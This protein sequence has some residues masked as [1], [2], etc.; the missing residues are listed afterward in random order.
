MALNLLVRFRIITDRG[1]NIFALNH[2]N[3]Y[4]DDSAEALEV[5]KFLGA[6]DPTGDVMTTGPDLGAEGIDHAI[7]T[8]TPIAYSFCDGGNLQTFTH[9]SLFPYVDKISNVNHFSCASLVCDLQISD[10]YT[11]QGASDFVT[12]DGA[13]EVTATSSNGDIKFSLDPGFDFYTEGQTVGIFTGLYAG[14]YTVT[15]KDELGCVDQITL[16]VPVPDFYNPIYRLEYDATKGAEGAPTSPTRIDILE[17]G[18][19]GDVTE[20]KGDADPFILRYNGAGE[21]NKFTPIIPSEARLTIMSETNFQFRHLFTQDERKYQIRYYKNLGTATPGFTPYELTPLENWQ[22]ILNGDFD[23]DIG[24]TQP[25]VEFTGSSLSST[26]SEITSTYIFEPGHLY[27]FA[28]EFQSLTSTPFGV[29]FTIRIE[30]VSGL[31]LL[32]KWVHVTDITSGTYSF[33]APEGAARITV[34]VFVPFSTS[35]NDTYRINSFTNQ[36]ATIPAGDAGPELKWLGYVI[37]SN[38]SEA[39][40]APPYPVQ[41]VATDGLADLKTYDYLDK[42]GNKYRD[43]QNTLTAITEILAKTDLSINI[44][45]AI[46]RYEE[47]MDQTDNDDPVNQCKFDPATFYHNNSIKSCAEVLE[48]LLK[49]FGARILQRNGKWC[50]YSIEEFVTAAD[51]REFDSNGL[52]IGN[53]TFNDAVNIDSP[54][55]QQRAA[56]INREQVLSM[57]PAYGKFFFEHTLLKNGSLIASYSF[58]LE[59]IIADPSGLV[60]F[61]NWNVNIANS[62]GATYGLKET[63]DIEGDFTFYLKYVLY[64]ANNVP[65]GVFLTAKPFILEYEN[66]DVFEF[67]FNYASLYAPVVDFGHTIWNK[68]K[69]MLKV[70]SYYYNENGGWTT[71]ADQKYN[72]VIIETANQVSEKRITGLL[73]N[74]S[75]LTEETVQIEFVLQNGYTYDYVNISAL[76]DTPTTT[77]AIGARKRVAQATTGMSYYKL[78]Y[79]TDAE[80]SPDIIRPDDYATTTN[81]RIWVREYGIVSSEGQ[82][83]EYNYIDNV[84]LLLHPKGAEA[85]ANITTTRNNNAGIKINFEEQYLL[86]D[87]DLENINNSERT[88]KNYFKKLDGTPTQVWERTYRAGTGKLLDLLSNDVVS[89][90]KRGSNKLTGSFI[91]DRE[92]LPTSV[93]IDVNG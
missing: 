34:I 11:I 71:D 46:N 83:V 66:V 18:Y 2:I 22:G 28:Y 52:L 14:E 20:I 5:Q 44:Q 93:M 23:W 51:Y 64:T 4:W 82:E 61:K 42:D 88:Y 80:S 79:G 76:K 10:T 19:T 59:D 17:R 54:I 8:N 89:Q 16:N 56:F 78:Q 21:I 13:L 70:G 67:S 73:R 39:Y 91:V 57:I 41:I 40:L 24:S 38:Y 85:P 72:D 32:E 31:P 3:V 27:S 1:G 45:S 47:D 35:S 55:I 29:R 63:K 25:T 92:V 75:E 36:T 43:D 69:W 65:D 9:K 62:P 77:K 50:I 49:P 37:S 81:E 60:Q 86:N 26:S 87:I 33:I 74:V 48:E 68:V 12:P 15:A 6:P 84:V 90:Y 58:E 53:G 30:P 7:V